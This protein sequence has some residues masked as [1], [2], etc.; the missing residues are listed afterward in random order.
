MQSSVKSDVQSTAH[1][2]SQLLNCVQNCVQNPKADY[3]RRLAKTD[4]SPADHGSGV[5]CVDKNP[6][7]DSSTDAG[8]A[9]ESTEGAER[10]Q[11]A[12]PLSQKANPEELVKLRAAL[13][14]YMGDFPPAGFEDSCLLRARG[15][16]VADIVDLIN[17]RWKAKKYRP[18]ARCGP[19]SWNWFLTVIAN[20]FSPAERG[21]W[22]EAVA[23]PHPDHRAS[24]D[25]LARGIEALETNPANSLVCSYR[26]KCGAEIRQ[27]ESRIEGIC[28]CGP[29]R[30]QRVECEPER[31]GNLVISWAMSDWK[32]LHKPQ[33]AF[34]DW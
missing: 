30:K 13:I 17:R 16:T 1:E 28:T 32:G 5:D 18:G 26:C 20:E 22:P 11:N 7:A 33:E 24:V 25:A 23:T 9:T 29:R 34:T 10:S 31:P 15:A 6:K 8:D 2:S 27:Y 14:A 3:S 4:E 12:K 19:R 21:R